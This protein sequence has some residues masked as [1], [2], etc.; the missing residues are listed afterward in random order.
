MAKAKVW[1]PSNVYET[2]VLGE[3]VSIG[4]FCEIGDGVTIGSGTRVGAMSFI[5]T[6]VTIEEDCFI[7]PR[8]TF[9]NDKYPPS[10][11][12]VHWQTTIVRKGASIGA[13]TTILCG[14]EIGDVLKSEQVRSLP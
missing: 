2:A 11:S 14:L 6:G 7:G 10:L 5:P 9:T 8:V 13:A 12:Q 4:A 3:D 1:E